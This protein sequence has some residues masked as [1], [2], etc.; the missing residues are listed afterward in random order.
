[1]NVQ[2]ARHGPTNAEL[3]AIRAFIGEC[4]TP[5]KGGLRGLRRAHRRRGVSLPLAFMKIATM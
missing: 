2:R 3:E 1:M 5:Q 4:L